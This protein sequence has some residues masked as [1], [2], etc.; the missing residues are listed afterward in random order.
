MKRTPIILL[1]DDNPGD[2]ELTREAFREVGL[3]AE[4]LIAESGVDAM[5]ILRRRAPHDAAPRPD[6]VLLDLNLPRLDGR[7]VLREMKEDAD[8]RRIPVVILTT[9]NRRQDV[10]QCYALFANSYI[11]K[12]AQWDS[13]LKIVKSLEHYW[14]DVASLPTA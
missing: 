4:F 5:D 12:P 9:S 8:L 14:F 3:A 1:V 11:V 7:D 6:F 13:F 2:I 10:E